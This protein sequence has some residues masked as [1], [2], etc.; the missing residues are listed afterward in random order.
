MQDMINHPA[1]YGLTNVTGQALNEAFFSG[2]QFIRRLLR[3][4]LSLTPRLPRYPNR[5]RWRWLSQDC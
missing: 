1:S 3:K 5:R 4:G 2:T